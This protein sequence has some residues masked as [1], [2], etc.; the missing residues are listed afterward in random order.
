MNILIA[1]PFLLHAHVKHGGGQQILRLIKGLHHLGHQ[2]H[3]LCL[4]ETGSRS[5]Q[6]D[7]DELARYCA[8]VKIFPRSKLN[9]LSKV[10]SF[11]KPSIPPHSRN[12]I[13]HDAQEYVKQLT[14]SGQVEVV[15]L[16]YTFMGEYARCVDRGKCFLLVD[17]IEIETRKY[18]MLMKANTTLARRLHAAITHFRTKRYEKKLLEN[19]DAVVTI[20]R[21]ETAF[22]RA[23][24]YPKRIHIVPSLIDTKEYAPSKRTVDENGLLFFGSFDHSPNVDS[25]TW[26]CKE[27]FPLITK[28]LPET[29]LHIVGANSIKK[30][31]WLKNNNITVVDT[32]PDIRDWIARAAVIVS[33]IVSGGGARIKNVE[34][35]AMGKALV[36][37]SLGAEG[38]NDSRAIG[39]FIEDTAIGF[40][41]RVIDLLK[42]AKLRTKI[43]DLGRKEIENKHDSLVNSKRLAQLFFELN[44]STPF[45]KDFDFSVFHRENQFKKML[46]L[47]L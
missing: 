37:T 22:I 8:E 1:F 33:P 41:K 23:F 30:V 43:G 10:V 21:E 6:S 29:A 40:A 28:K 38:L 14:S 27:V 46:P 16:V 44:T 5:F 35:L 2:I 39:Y 32:V 3:L 31:G 24:C 18:S 11:L 19:V 20:S 45:Y 12:L 34:T 26:F 9:F 47:L 17:T 13:I 42:D 15:Y 36:T 25:I 7:I 4:S